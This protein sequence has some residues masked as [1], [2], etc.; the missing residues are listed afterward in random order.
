MT[1]RRLG[2]ALAS[3]L[4]VL[5]V[6][7]CTAGDPAATPTTTSPP[8]SAAPPST[9]TS[10]PTTEAT[11]T[12]TTTTTTAAP[13]GAA[14]AVDRL[15]VRTADDPALPDYRRAEFGDDWDYDPTTGC[16]VRERVL[17]EES[18][19]EPTVD[20]RCR[21]TVGRWRSAYD[22]VETDDPADLQIDHLVPLS[23]AWRSGAATWTYERR[24]AFANDLV[25]PET[26]IAVT[27]HTN[28]SKGD[29][30]PDEWLPPDRA[31][32]CDYAAAWVAVKLRWG[33][34]VTGPEK[35]TLVS[36]LSGCGA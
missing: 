12:S 14:A 30:S 36:V 25:E 24:H 29:R 7:G 34:S 2:P 20:D 23:D 17:I 16:N 28:Q 15:E 31:S 32:W 21:T 13:P 1:A 26:L 4:V 9:T 33:L 22:G 5:A 11:T 35:S 19:V 18:I 3:A 6:A 10:A 27:G 8:V